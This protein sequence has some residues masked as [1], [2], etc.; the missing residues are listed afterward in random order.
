M[1]LVSAPGLHYSDIALLPTAQQSESGIK[2]ALAHAESDASEGSVT[3][4]PYLPLRRTSAATP[5]QRLA[6]KFV[7]ECGAVVESSELRNFWAG[8]QGKT[9]RIEL[10][11]GL[12]EWELSGADARRG[13]AQIMERVG[14][15]GRV[16]VLGT[17]G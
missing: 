6:S 10:V 14:T 15:H 2:A 1:L 7:K 3:R 13:R 8:E 4:H 11:E 17:G 9:L 5:A 12:D 16:R